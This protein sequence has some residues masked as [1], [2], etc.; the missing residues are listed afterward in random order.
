MTESITTYEHLDPAAV[1]SE[2]SQVERR[3]V[4]DTLDEVGPDAPTLCA[5]WNAHRLVAH[6]HAR[7]ASPLL[8]A[9]APIARL[10][11]RVA[12]RIAHRTGFSRL[13][14]EV[15]AGPPRILS[16][17][18]SRLEA[19]VNTLEFYIHHEDL[20]R[21]APSWEPRVLPSWAED[22][23]WVRVGGL[24]RFR[25]RGNRGAIAFER[26]DTG[27]R[28]GSGEDADIVVRG[29]PSELAL[30]ASG[31]GRVSRVEV[32]GA[33]SAVAAYNRARSTA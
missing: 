4:C 3:L 21:A 18:L 14:D 9:T 5:G 13:V 28:S 6:L 2:V 25:S 32:R 8:A 11:D 1:A 30:H 23:I 7:E 15:R 33:A 12:A 19:H 20:R 27:Q 22:K 26:L 16:H 24:A 17:R 10:S 31:R 29:L